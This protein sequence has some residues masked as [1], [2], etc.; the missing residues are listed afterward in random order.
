MPLSVTKQGLSIFGTKG[1]TANKLRL[2]KGIGIDPDEIIIGS[3][4]ATA[5]VVANDAKTEEKTFAQVLQNM[6]Y[7]AWVCGGADD[8][9]QLL[10]ADAYVGS[11]GRV[12]LSETAAGFQCA[13]Q[14]VLNAV[15]EGQGE[16]LTKIVL[17]NAAINPFIIP[18][19]GGNI[20]NCKVE[21]PAGYTGDA[22]KFDAADSWQYR[23][24]LLGGMYL[25]QSGVNYTGR[26]LLITRDVGG[27]FNTN[28]FGQPITMR[29]FDFGFRFE[30]LS[31]DYPA[32]VNGNVFPVINLIH[33][34][35]GIKLY[36]QHRMYEN[37]FG[38]VTNQAMDGALAT[39]DLEFV[40]DV[41]ATTHNFFKSVIDS[42]I[43]ATGYS[44][45]ISKYGI[46]C[47]IT[48]AL[49][50]R[51]QDLG[52]NKI[53]NLYP[54]STNVL[55]T[56]DRH[57]QTSLKN[58]LGASLAEHLYGADFVIISQATEGSA[59]AIDISGNNKKI[60]LTGSPTFGSHAQTG[61]PILT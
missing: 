5:Y 45:K 61:F 58:L 49:C 18:K 1:W 20:L 54:S 30:N 2:G 26:G 40:N 53:T 24:G 21:V 11:G 48:G 9:V 19:P 39:L 35:T 3:L 51:V 31:A 4:G 36:S 33:N 27:V 14:L 47:E 15:F 29:G 25:Y 56:Q 16:E 44:V 43:P 50:G 59:K 13:A 37:V 41:G 8:D 6:G 17:T 46:G 57:T 10:A 22:I 32:N 7:P 12:I 23:H 42:D 38:I 28:T 52:L 60:A 55:V 34:K